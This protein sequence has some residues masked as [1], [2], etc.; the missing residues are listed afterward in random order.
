MKNKKYI[1]LRRNDVPLFNTQDMS[2][3]DKREVFKTCCKEW[4]KTERCK[5][6]EMG[7]TIRRRISEENK[8][9]R[10]SINAPSKNL[11]AIATCL[12]AAKDL[13]EVFQDK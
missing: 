3:E 9:K 7:K 12:G 8:T 6:R 1:Q 10:D 13:I 5:S 2:S 4:G 11:N